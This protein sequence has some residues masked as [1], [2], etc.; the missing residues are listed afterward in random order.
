MSKEQV[1]DIGLSL[2]E[3]VL[4]R[5]DPGPTRKKLLEVFLS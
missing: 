3:A 4:K 2:R 5:F 1:M